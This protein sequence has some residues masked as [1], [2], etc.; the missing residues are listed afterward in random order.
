MF[1][2]NSMIYLREGDWVVF[3]ILVCLF[4]DFC[5]ELVVNFFYK[6]FDVFS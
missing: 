2:L 5:S 3:I 4:L 1:G 6:L